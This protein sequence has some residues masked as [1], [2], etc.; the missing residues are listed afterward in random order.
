[1]TTLMFTRLLYLGKTLVFVV[2]FFWG[3]GEVNLF[4][5]AKQK[6]NFVS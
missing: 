6:I 4:P 3:G 1:M 5:L 2:V